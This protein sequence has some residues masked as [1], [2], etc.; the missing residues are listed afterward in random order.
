MIEV[1]KHSGFHLETKTFFS[2]SNKRKVKRDIHYYIYIPAQLNINESTFPK[3]SMINMLSTYGRFGSP[4]LNFEELIDENNKKSHLSKIKEL[5][6]LDNISEDKVIHEMQ[7]L[8]NAVRHESKRY[9]SI[10]KRYLSQKNF[11]ATEL[12]LNDYIFYVST[13]LKIFRGLSTSGENEN[14]LNALNWTDENLSIIVEKEANSISRILKKKEEYVDIGKKLKTFCQEEEK[15]RVKKGYITG[16]ATDNIDSEKASYRVSLLKKWAQSV[17]YLTPVESNIPKHIG[18]IFA[19]VAAAV[20]MTFAT[21]A[22]IYAEKIFS[23]NSY[24]WALIIIIAY[25]F[26]DRIKEGLRAIT[27]TLLPKLLADSIYKFVKPGED[28]WVCKS[29]VQVSIDKARDQSDE[30]NKT[31]DIDNNPFLSVLPDEDVIHYSRYIKINKQDSKCKYESGTFTLINRIRLDDL[32]REMDDTS[33]IK[34]IVKRNQIDLNRAY[35]LHLVVHE[36]NQK[37]NIDEKQLHRIVMNKDGIIRIDKI[38]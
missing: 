13:L 22:S 29:K 25:V 31:R 37:D 35:Y 1:R 38:L 17:L 16:M 14:I 3:S 2:F 33:P 21:L 28:K 4:I 7:L 26:K 6:D 34:K 11:N 20:A 15:Y 18:Q 9:T 36:I 24:Q 8:S 23:K 10:I 32:T 5:L 12:T 30:I 27:S 19:G